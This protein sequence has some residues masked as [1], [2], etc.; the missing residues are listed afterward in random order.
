MDRVH[1]S[2][3]VL[4]ISILIVSFTL[5]SAGCALKPTAPANSDSSMPVSTI[6]SIYASG[7]PFDFSKLGNF[8]F[9][10]VIEISVGEKEDQLTYA[11]KGELAEEGPADFAIANNG[12]IYILDSCRGS[13]GVDNRISVYSGGTWVRNIDYSANVEF[14]SKITILNNN[15]YVFGGIYNTG[16]T[17]L[18][19]MSLDGEFQT[20]YTFS[21]EY[22]P[23]NTGSLTAID[24]R[25]IIFGLGNNK[26]FELD[27]DAM[28]FVES[29]VIVDVK[30]V[31]N[32]TKHVT[33]GKSEW[34]VK[35]EDFKANFDVLGKTE[36][37][38]AYLI[39]YQP[40]NVLCK[41]DKNGIPTAQISS[42]D[43]LKDFVY[44]SDRY[45]VAEDGSLYLM[46]A[47]ESSIIIYKSSVS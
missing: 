34:D 41:Y 46:V 37:N 45:Y 33:Y 38:D 20:R 22:E 23:I 30:T 39:F 6:S 2:K 40:T 8:E 26:I 31:D 4:V 25:L 13:G 10:K 43:Y 27:E 3:N 1:I 9:D 15:I 47:K 16:D 19:K 24:N 5:T 12:D 35:V 21:S 42:S 18:V 36:D 28:K 7:E 11:F 32:Y 44:I 29:D 17:Y 14:G